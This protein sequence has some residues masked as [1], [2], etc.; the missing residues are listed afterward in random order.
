MP[1]ITLEFLKKEIR[2]LDSNVE[3]GSDDFKTAL[4]LLASLVVGPNIKKIAHFVKLP[5]SYVGK[6]SK[7]MRENKI[8]KGTETY[9]DNWFKKKEGVVAFWLDVCVA[10][11]HMKR[12]KRAVK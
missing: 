4:V 8:W 11:G 7:R 12:E 5:R 9:C 6:I 1:K 2:R 10:L 3:E